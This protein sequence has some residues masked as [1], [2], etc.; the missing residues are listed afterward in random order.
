[1]YIYVCV[2]TYFCKELTARFKNKQIKTQMNNSSRDLA[3]VD[4]LLRDST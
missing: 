2:Y 3:A 4:M 1:M